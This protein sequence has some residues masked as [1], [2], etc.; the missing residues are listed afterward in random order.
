MSDPRPDW[1]WLAALA[2][3]PSHS[4]ARV[5]VAEDDPAMRALVVEALRK[6]GYV[7][8]EASDG[9]RLLVTLARDFV[10]EAGGEAFDLLITD[11]RMPVCTGLQIVEQLRA[12]HCRIPIILMTAFGDDGTRRRARSLAAL[13]LDKPFPLAELRS[14]TACLLREPGLAPERHVGLPWRAP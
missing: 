7:V 11:L 4:P 8:S 14:A 12:V 3:P 5:L 2:M 13:L 9:G 6:D 10:D 1:E